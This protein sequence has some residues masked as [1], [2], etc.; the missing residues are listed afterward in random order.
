[1]G[2][3]RA[4]DIGSIYVANTCDGLPDVSSGLADN[5]LA[6]RSARKAAIYIAANVKNLRNRNNAKKLMFTTAYLDCFTWFCDGEE[7]E[8]DCQQHI[9]SL[10]TLHC[11]IIT[12]CN[13][14]IRSSYCPHYEFI[15]VD[16]KL[17]HWCDAHGLNKGIRKQRPMFESKVEMSAKLDTQHLR[18]RADRKAKHNFR[19]R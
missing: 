1:L 19:E 15:D 6:W 18:E 3:T 10:S 7:W 17:H 13:T 5:N 9:Q 2:E 16:D 8:S 4:I 12:Y 11:E 14:M